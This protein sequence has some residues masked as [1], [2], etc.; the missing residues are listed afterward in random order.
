MRCPLCNSESN[1]I[2]KSKGTTS[3]EILLRCNE[4]G[5]T[6]RETIVTEKPVDCRVVVSEYE[7]SEKKFI[8][9]YSHE[10]LQVGQII[11]VKGR[12]AEITSIETKRGGRIWESPLSDVETIWASYIDTPA[13]VG[14]SVDFGGRVVSNKV[15]VDRD[16]EFEIGDIVKLGNLLFKIYSLK[17]LERKMRKGFARASVTKRVYGRPIEGIKR[18]KYDLSSKVVRKIPEE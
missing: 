7:K 4:C 14:V 18:H 8:K 1:K 15:E 13:R 12:E 5:N 9:L 2:L 11:E 17:T 6:F 10:N 3:K 16:F